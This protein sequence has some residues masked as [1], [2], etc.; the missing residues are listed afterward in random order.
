MHAS[1]DLYYTSYQTILCS[2]QKHKINGTY[3]INIMCMYV[4]VCHACMQSGKHI[5][6]VNLSL[7]KHAKLA[8]YTSKLKF[9]HVNLFKRL[10]S[11]MMLV[12]A[13]VFLFLALVNIVL[14]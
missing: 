11:M 10:F 13:T 2:V 5:Q 14:C 12:C 7:C 9:L 6:L 8:E 1:S 3:T 4:H